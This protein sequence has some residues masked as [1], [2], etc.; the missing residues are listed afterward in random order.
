M[1]GDVNEKLG[2]S[3]SVNVRGPTGI[4]R[5]MKAV[6]DTGHDGAL[7]LPFAIVH[8]L[9]LTPGGPALVT[10]GDGQRRVRRAY[11]AAVV[12]DGEM[13]RVRLLCEEGDTLI[14]TALL[15]GYKLEVEFEVGGSVGI[16]PLP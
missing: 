5:Q 10:Y 8:A 3:V 9:A 13:R 14:G 16:T 1:Q 4:T 2:A 6:I 15:K 7:S 12:W 11:H